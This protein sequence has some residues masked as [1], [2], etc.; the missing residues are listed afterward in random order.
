VVGHRFVVSS[1]PA[2]VVDALGF[3]R[4]TNDPPVQRHM[5]PNANIRAQLTLPTPRLA[6]DKVV[7]CLGS[8]TTAGCR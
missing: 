1:P 5:E 4:A 7:P 6:V 8:T 2:R 3:N